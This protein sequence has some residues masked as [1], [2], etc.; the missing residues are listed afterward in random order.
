MGR[1]LPGQNLTPGSSRNSRETS[2]GL[3]AGGRKRFCPALHLSAPHHLGLES[4]H[5]FQDV[6]F[7]P[8]GSDSSL[9]GMH[10]AEGPLAPLPGLL[11]WGGEK[12]SPDPASS[13]RMA[14][15]RA[16][17]CPSL[18][19]PEVGERD[20]NS[21]HSSERRLTR[22]QRAGCHSFWTG[23][24]G[25]H[26]PPHPPRLA[27]SRHLKYLQRS[28]Q[29]SW[30]GTLPD[31]PSLPS[32]PGDTL[33]RFCQVWNVPVYHQCQPGSKTSRLREACP[34]SGGGMGGRWAE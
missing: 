28:L 15:P 18:S 8:S 19:S 30:G 24:S 12:C 25:M 7:I 9:G 13:S 32:A 29:L 20:R 4:F 5:F 26:P 16:P 6:C 27:H 22:T 33:L 31:I 10:R 17:P 3:R 1:T 2:S 11:G 23:S 21:P 34:P 14:A